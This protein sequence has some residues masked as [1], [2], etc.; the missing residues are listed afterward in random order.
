VLY[1]PTELQS[2]VYT[3][4][5]FICCIGGLLSSKSKVPVKF[6]LDADLSESECHKLLDYYTP[7]HMKRNKTSQK[8]FI[9]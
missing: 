5:M 7:Q 4:L 8:L 1:T 3:L 9:R 2:P 6:S